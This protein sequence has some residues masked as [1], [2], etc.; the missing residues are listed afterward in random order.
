MKQPGPGFE[1][2]FGI[3]HGGEIPFVFQTVPILDPN[4][5]PAV[6]ELVHTIGDY[7][8]NFAYHLDPNSKSGPKWPIYGNTATS[9][10]LLASNVTTFK[11]SARK[12]ATDFV[13]ANSP[14]LYV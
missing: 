3:Q 2:L 14:N 8:I 7:W 10:Q 5:S 13:I 1:P 4:A 9:L 11:D 12:Q 6:V